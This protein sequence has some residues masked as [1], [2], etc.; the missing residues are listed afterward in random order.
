MHDIL[1]SRPRTVFDSWENSDCSF[2][3]LFGHRLSS[4]MKE[5]PV[6]SMSES[7]SDRRSNLRSVTEVHVQTRTLIT[8]ECTARLRSAERYCQ[9]Q[10]SEKLVVLRKKLQHNRENTVYT[11]PH[12][13]NYVSNSKPITTSHTWYIR[14]STVAHTGC[15]MCSI[16]IFRYLLPIYFP[17][18]PFVCE[19]Y[20]HFYS[21]YCQACSSISLHTG[22]DKRDQKQLF[23]SHRL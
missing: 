23:S 17:I 5:L 20:K 1:V 13:G 2:C 21:L 7:R 4:L 12:Y 14:Y 6:D 22:D 3:Y 11:W 19:R 15:A 16:D 18:F 10:F 8:R 9:E